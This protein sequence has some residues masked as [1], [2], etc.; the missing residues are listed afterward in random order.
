MKKILLFSSLLVLSLMSCSNQN[1]SFSSNISSSSNDSSLSSTIDTSS[2]ENYEEITIDFTNLTMY[3]GGENLSDKGPSD[4]FISFFNNEKEILKDASF[5]KIFIQNIE[6]KSGEKK[7]HLTI[8]SSSSN[9]NMS[10]NFNYQ[11][12]S[13]DINCKAYYKYI[14]YND[15]YNNDLNCNLT[16]G[17]QTLKIN[18][19][20][21]SGVSNDVSLN[22]SFASP[23][24][25]ISIK[26]SEE[27]GSHRVFI[28]SISLK[29]IK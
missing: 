4:K 29:Y 16:I 12:K 2:I 9:G 10:L 24:S 7:N 3:N 25:S 23:T 18:D 14:S 11:I 28:N 8:G 19:D 26:S 6:E 5:T 22:F 21:T 15:T 1:Q 27:E 17:D 13:I 20:T